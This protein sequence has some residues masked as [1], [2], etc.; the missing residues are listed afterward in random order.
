MGFFRITLAE[1]GSSGKILN[2]GLGVAG[3][4]A[5]EILPAAFMINFRTISLDWYRARE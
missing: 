2:A 4:V 5:L 3:R 1:E